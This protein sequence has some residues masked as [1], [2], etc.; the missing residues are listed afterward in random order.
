[1]T[2]TSPLPCISRADRLFMNTY[3]RFPVCI[4]KGEGCTLYGTDGK[5]YLDFLSGIAV[6]SLG[7]CHP[8]VTKAVSEQAARLVHVSNLFYTLPQT[9]LAELLVADS[10]ADRVFFAN[11]GAEA[12]EAAIKLARK[13]TAPERFEIITLEGSFHGRTL[14]TIAA[15]GQPKFQ[16]GFC[17]MPQGFRHAPFGDFTALEKMT[18]SHTAAIMVEPVQG[19]SGVRP[20]T[21]EYLTQVRELCDRQRILL[22]FDEVQTGMG[23]TGKL[24]A[25]EHYGVTPDIMTLAKALGNGLPI[26]ATLATEEVAQAFVP[27]SHASTFGGNP[28]AAAAAVVVVQTLTAPGFLDEVLHKGK[29]LAEALGRIATRHPE[30]ATGV[31]G[32]G[33][34]QALVLTE[35]G[36]TR[37]SDMINA[38]LQRGVL[39]NFAGSAVLRFAPPLVVTEEEIRRLADALESVLSC[40]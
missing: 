17:P 33:L 36:I 37:G 20:L 24:F 11:S 13:A 5:K 22:I 31:R 6:C 1:M 9:E 29:I 25:H 35:Q 16:Q 34:L 12:N 2:D 30:I 10:F 32:M 21:Q 8:A 15:T 3:A 28:V 18:D 7:H 27:G 14:A 19:E 4:E 38:L 40:V 39:A 26:G 23:R